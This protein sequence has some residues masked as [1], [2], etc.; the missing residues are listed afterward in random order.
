MTKQTIIDKTIQAI[1]QLPPDKAE[2]IS[3][4]A[5]FVLKK[6]EEHSIIANIQKIVSDSSTFN[7]LLEDE[8]LYSVND[9][10]ERF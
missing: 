8:E 5:D 10:K 1:N 3:D 9:I 7:F 2:E 4:F 6:F